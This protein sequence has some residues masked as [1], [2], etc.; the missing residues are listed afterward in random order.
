M[1]DMTTKQNE[2]E[3][4][5]LVPNA[6]GTWETVIADTAPAPNAAPLSAEGSYPVKMYYGR[7]D[8]NGSCTVE[9]EVCRNRD[10]LIQTLNWIGQCGNPPLSLWAYDHEQPIEGALAE[11]LNRSYERGSRQRWQ[12]LMEIETETS[13]HVSLEALIYDAEN[14]T[15]ASNAVVFPNKE[16]DR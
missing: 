7:I 3:K 1:T 2:S 12:T 15:D 13:P 10:T 14:K 5:Y 8:L 9:M 4:V 6:N 11:I 16:P